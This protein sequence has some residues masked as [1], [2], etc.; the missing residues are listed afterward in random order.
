MKD[1]VKERKESKIKLKMLYDQ[2]VIDKKQYFENLKQ[3]DNKLID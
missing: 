1:K 3:V 2:G